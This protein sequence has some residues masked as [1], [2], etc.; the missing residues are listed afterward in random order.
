MVLLSRVDRYDFANDTSVIFAS[1]FF[2]SSS[3]CRAW[4]RAKVAR[5][6][7]LI[8]VELGW[9]SLD[10]RCGCGERGEGW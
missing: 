8:V 1:C 2:F 9:D 3:R 4:I 5:F 6:A 7:V 10:L